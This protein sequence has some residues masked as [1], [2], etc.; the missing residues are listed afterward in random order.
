MKNLMNIYFDIIW[1]QHKID[2]IYFD[3]IIGYS[4]HN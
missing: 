3:A 2:I 1:I 4:F